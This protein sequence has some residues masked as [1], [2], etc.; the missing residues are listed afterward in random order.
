MIIHDSLILCIFHAQN[1]STFHHFF[2]RR[3]KSLQLL[4]FFPLFLGVIVV[5]IEAVG[6]PSKWPTMCRV[7]S[8]NTER[9]SPARR[10]SGGRV[11]SRKV[12]PSASR[13]P[14]CP[15]RRPPGRISFG[16]RPRLRRTSSRYVN[17][18]SRRTTWTLTPRITTLIM[19]RRKLRKR[20]S[21]W[22]SWHPLGVL[23]TGRTKKFC[24]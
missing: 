22:N 3:K 16:T 12:G 8:R 19:V 7:L 1:S 2:I 21:L 15:T 4:F 24:S 20:G 6:S 23:D 18:P 11:S 10:R 5:R 14:K 13:K 9:R 17:S